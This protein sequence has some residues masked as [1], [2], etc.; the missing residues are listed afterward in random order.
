LDE[1]LTD[2]SSLIVPVKLIEEI[3]MAYDDTRARVLPVYFV[4]DE[5][6]SMSAHIE[7]L[8]Q[9]LRHLYDAF[10]RD[11]LAA[12]KVRFSVIGF[13]DTVIP[14]LSLAQLTDIEPE[15]LPVLRPI[16]ST[17]YRA[18]FEDLLYRLPADVA[19]LKGRGLQVHRP[20][21]FFLTDGAPNPGDEWEAAYARLAGI[22]ESP[23]ILAFGVEAAD[24]A[25]I[26]RVASN[27]GWAFVAENGAETGHALVEFMQA[28]TRSVVA[29]AR[30]VASGNLELEMERPAGFKVAAPLL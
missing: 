15:Q 6:Q 2:G 3:P 11:T 27:P 12:A 26:A 8:N 20:A 5:S 14:H 9:G 22:R 19:D 25:T 29:S 24:E 16:A 21:V 18:A 1:Q 7:V 17:S 10:Q 13:S 30:A 23:N 4:A 28:L